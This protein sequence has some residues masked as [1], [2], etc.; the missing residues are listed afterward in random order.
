MFN[1]NIKKDIGYEMFE[2]KLISAL[3]IICLNLFSDFSSLI[4]LLL[5]WMWKIILV[6]GS[7]HGGCIPTVVIF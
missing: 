2:F 6:S 7:Q 4:L 5:N 3:R 1:I